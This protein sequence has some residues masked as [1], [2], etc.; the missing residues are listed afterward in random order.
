MQSSQQRAER[1]RARGGAPPM[2]ST[3]GCKPEMPPASSPTPAGDQNER[4]PREAEE[5]GLGAAKGEGVDRS[6]GTSFRCAS[7]GAP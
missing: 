3:I 4:R 7:P 2:E 6:D 5:G 1:R